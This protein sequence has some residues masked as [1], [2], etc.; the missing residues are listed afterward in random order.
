MIGVLDYGLGN[1]GSIVRMFNRIGK[2]AKI[3]RNKDEFDSNFGLVLP[4][5]GSFDAAMI[6]IADLGLIEPIIKHANNGNPLL[7]ICLGM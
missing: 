1:V 2:S 4:G 6:K 3:I 7:G 5:V